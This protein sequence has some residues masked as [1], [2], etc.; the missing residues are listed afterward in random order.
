MITVAENARVMGNAARKR[1]E[2]AFDLNQWVGRHR[3]IFEQLLGRN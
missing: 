2:T 1:A 3:T